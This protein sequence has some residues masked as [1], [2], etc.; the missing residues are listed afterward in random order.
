MQ[1]VPEHIDELIA[2]T[3]AAEAT[4]A[5]MEELLN[6][7]QQHETHELYYQQCAAIFSNTVSGDTLSYNTDEAWGKVKEQLTGSN[8]RPLNP[9][10]VT[11]EW[12]YF[13]RIAAILV[14][15]AGFGWW[16]HTLIPPAY[17]QI[18]TAENKVL[19]DTLPDGSLIT[20]N[21]N[22]SLSYS[23]DFGKKERRLKLKGEAFFNVQHETEQPFIIEANGIIIQ[24]IGTA[25][26]VKAS[27]DSSVVEVMV[28]EGEVHFY[29]EGT[30]GLYLHKGQGGIYRKSDSS[31]TKF[32][33]HNTML[34][35]YRTGI[36]DFS[37]ALLSDVIPAIERMYGVHIIA[38][39]NIENCRITVH[40][41]HETFETVLNVICETLNLTV[42]KNENRILLKGAPCKN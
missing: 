1:T 19:H 28:E 38:E 20:L 30:G 39:K 17:N 7:R 34:T 18:I 11:I 13:V 9:A 27:D 36:L 40:F 23:S 15:I 31:M 41:E 6:W 2:L 3:L 22:A 24:D 33:V 5:Q 25:F 37:N 4:P 8:I 12:K 14:L 42:D 26:N 32:E 21:K 35:A 29:Q 10:P 16:I